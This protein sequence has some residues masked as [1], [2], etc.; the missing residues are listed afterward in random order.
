LKAADSI[1][2]VSAD[3]AQKFAAQINDLRDVHVLTFSPVS[4][5]AIDIMREG[6]HISMRRSGETW[7]VTAPIAVAADDGTINGLLS[8]L[9]ELRA[10]QFVAD[11]ATDLDKFGLASPVATVNLLGTATNS[12]AQLLVGTLDA[13]N[14]VRFVKRTDEPFIYGVATNIL[15]LLPSNVLAVRTRWIRE[16]S[17]E[18]ITR[19]EI[20][21]PASPLVAERASSTN[22]WRLVEPAQGVIDVDGLQKLIESFTQLHVDRFVS[23]D[24]KLESPE[25]TVKASVVEKTY[26]LTIGK[27]TETGERYASWSDP[28]LTF[29]IPSVL[30]ERFLKPLVV[31]PAAAASN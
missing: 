20:Q 4:V 8:Q 26:M 23:A 3:T 7:Q 29:V 9:H 2:T 27:P 21:R 5:Q 22:A 13:S 12:L 16:V 10:T 28:P 19:I 30:A 1:F 24:T 11:V 18:Q 6:E 15:A 25:A 14:S 31:T 17:P